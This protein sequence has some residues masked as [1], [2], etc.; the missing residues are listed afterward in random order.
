[1]RLV[2]IWRHGTNSFESKKA[3]PHIPILIATG[4]ICLFHFMF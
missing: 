1:M 4:R 2:R 3:D